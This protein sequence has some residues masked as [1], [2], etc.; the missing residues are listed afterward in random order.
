MKSLSASLQESCARE[1]ELSAMKAEAQ[2]QASTKQQEANHLSGLL[3]AKEKEVRVCSFTVEP[4]HTEHSRD[5]SLLRTL[6]QSRWHRAVY[7]STSELRTPLYT[8]QPVWVP[9]V[10]SIQRFHCMRTYG[11]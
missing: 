2:G 5:I 3:A 7:K 4:F 10:S 1:N 6:S 8:G 9:M 11:T